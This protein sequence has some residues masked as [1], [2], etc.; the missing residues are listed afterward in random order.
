MLEGVEQTA[1]SALKKV[2]DIRYAM[3]CDMQKMQSRKIKNAR[4]I[5]SCIY[6]KPGLVLN[7]SW[8]FIEMNKTNKPIL[9]SR[10]L[11]FLQRLALRNFYG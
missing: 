4:D 3:E 1:K 2:N 11:T 5:V 10:V 7:Y 6:E 9:Q 8:T